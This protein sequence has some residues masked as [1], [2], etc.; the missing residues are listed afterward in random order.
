MVCSS[1]VDVRLSEG[2][3]PGVP[4]SVLVTRLW[5][6]LAWFLVVTITEFL[7]GRPYMSVP[8]K[9]GTGMP[10]A[11]TTLAFCDHHPS[12]SLTSVVG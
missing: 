4:S 11:A 6:F 12:F 8:N 10:G 7:S 2:P 1:M 3:S 5:S 9:T